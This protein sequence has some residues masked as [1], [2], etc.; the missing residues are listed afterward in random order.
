[1]I[2]DDDIII[3]YQECLA[4]YTVDG[5]TPEYDARKQARQDTVERLIKNGLSRQDAVFKLYKLRKELNN[6]LTE[7]Y[8]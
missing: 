8:V 2:I 6:G 4:K 7:F 3:Y 5:F 1:M